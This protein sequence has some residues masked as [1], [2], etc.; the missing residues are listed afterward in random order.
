MRRVGP[1]QAQQPTTQAQQFPSPAQQFPPDQAAPA[2]PGQ[3]QPISFPHSTLPPQQTTPQT[4]AP[5]VQPPLT[6]TQQPVASSATTPQPQPSG[7]EQQ[8]PNPPRVSFMGGLLTVAAENSTLADILKAIEAVT[9]ASLEGTQPDRERVFGQ[10]G[11][12]A[13]RQVLNSILSGSHYDFILTGA[14]DDPG[15]VERIM[16]SPHGTAPAV[17]GS[18]NQAMARQNPTPNPDDEDN[19]LAAQPEIQQQAPPPP[20]PS[21]QVQPPGQQLP[22]QVKTPEQL[23]QELQRLRQQQQQQQPQQAPGNNPR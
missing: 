5:A 10:F 8:P 12:A 2:S 11:P 21:E 9:H 3:R 17:R 4:Q 1:G 16:L 7:A 22:Q 15:S 6:A 18:T 23:L 14:I 20:V 13:P 19:D